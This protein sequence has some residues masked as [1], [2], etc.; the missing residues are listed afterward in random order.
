VLLCVLAGLLGSELWFLASPGILA[1]RYD[2]ISYFRPAL[3]VNHN[4]NNQM[5]RLGAIELYSGIGSLDCVLTLGT[6][7]YCLYRISRTLGAKLAMFPLLT[8]IVMFPVKGMYIILFS[9]IPVLTYPF[10]SP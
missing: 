4:E 6:F 5:I 9:A 7:F 8:S 3:L 1:G 2:R 10:Q